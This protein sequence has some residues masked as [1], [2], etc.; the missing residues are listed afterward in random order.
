MKTSAAPRSWGLFTLTIAR[1]PCPCADCIAHLRARS[2]D[3]NGAT[4]HD[5]ASWSIFLAKACPGLDPG[6]AA[7]RRRKCDQCK[8]S[9]GNAMQ[10]L[11]GKTAIVTGAASG[12]GLGMAR[13]FARE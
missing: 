2:V 8:E 13:A 12:I 3:H 9:R 6:C 1:S 7:V 10:Q 4:V 5:A 11:E